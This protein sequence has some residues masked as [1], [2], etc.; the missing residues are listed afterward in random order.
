VRRTSCKRRRI[1]GQLQPGVPPSEDVHLPVHDRRRTPS[2]K[3]IKSGTAHTVASAWVKLR[4]RCIMRRSAV[5][6][7]AINSSIEKND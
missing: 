5:R 2:L 4:A 1:N 3:T 6:R 7:R